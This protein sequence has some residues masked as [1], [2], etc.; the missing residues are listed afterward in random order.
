MKKKLF[1]EIFFH[2]IFFLNF[3]RIIFFQ[4]INLLF[5]YQEF[6]FLFQEFFCT[7][8]KNY[9]FTFQMMAL[10][11]RHLKSKKNESSFVRS[12]EQ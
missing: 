8:L 3:S 5:F 10:I 7:K 11:R 12:I 9:F 6:F 2:L 4:E 1:Q